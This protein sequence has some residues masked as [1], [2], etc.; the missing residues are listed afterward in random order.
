MR[1]DAIAHIEE[2]FQMVEPERKFSFGFTSLLIVD[3][4]LD[5]DGYLS[6]NLTEQLYVVLRERVLASGGDAQHTQPPAVRDERNAATRIES[7]VVGPSGVVRVKPFKV[8]FTDEDRLAGSECQP[9]CGALHW[10]WG[11]AREDRQFN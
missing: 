4:V 10:Y 11:A 8:G 2:K 1:G 9:A 6:A 7:G 3:G 5:G